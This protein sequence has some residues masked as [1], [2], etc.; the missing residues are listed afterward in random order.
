MSEDD[1]TVTRAAPRAPPVTVPRV[2]LRYHIVGYVGRGGMGTV[3]RVIDRELGEIVALKVLG[4]D[5]RDTPEALGMFR[6]EARL[7]R[8][9]T[10][11]NV[12]RIYDIGEHEGDRFLTMELVE[13]ESLRT[14]SDRHAPLP[15]PEVVRIGTALCAGLSAIHAASI[16]HLDLKPANVLLDPHGRIAITDFGVARALSDPRPGAVG[17]P[18]YMAPEQLDE[19]GKVDERTDLYAVGA[20]LYE[21]ATGN[22][23]WDGPP[24]L[25]VRRKREGK[26]PNPRD[27][28]ASLPDAFVDVVRRCLACEP[29]E[30]PASADEVAGVLAEITAGPGF[31]PQVPSVRSFGAQKH[32]V[33]VSFENQAGPGSDYL[34]RGVASELAKQL[35]SMSGLRIRCVE[36]PR[37]KETDFYRTLGAD[38]VVDGALLPD[39][40]MELRAVVVDDGYR[41]WSR[42]FVDAAKH[43]AEIVSGAT[44]ALHTALAPASTRA[45]SA[46]ADG[47]AHDLYLRGRY[48]A[49]R[50]WFEGGDESARLLGEAHAAA[51]HDRQ[52]AAAYALALARQFAIADLGVESCEKARR[53]ARRVLVDGASGTAHVALALTHWYCGEGAAAASELRLAAESPPPLSASV[54]EWLGTVLLEIGEL[55]RGLRLVERASEIEPRFVHV[56]RLRARRAALLGDFATAEREL[57]AEPD[58]RDAEANFGFRARF[59]LWREDRAAAR[60]MMVERNATADG[61]QMLEICAERIISDEARRAID[62]LLP[63]AGNPRRTAWYAQLRAE[64]FAVAGGHD[65]VLAS[66]E[67]LE[68]AYF[69][70]ILW[71]E[72]CPLI[73]RYSGTPRWNKLRE[74]VERRVR[75][76]REL[77]A[78]VTLDDA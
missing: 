29:S 30:R 60:A 47:T 7:A 18:M 1:E 68:D 75:P 28:V 78:D 23:A 38:V 59:L 11:P 24:D 54:F 42:T 66:L 32:V 37:A 14:Y 36:R 33:V 73:A 13:G 69:L 4:T 67:A 58:D 77:L 72:R 52:I 65:E 17:T 2:P 61:K 12:V 64:I 63:L 62:A 44:D 5:L 20:I 57:I 10:H 50:Q 35:R 15:L 41:L 49:P 16:V 19:K 34:A 25:L 26:V 56:A 6:D 45:V 76:I 22:R 53:I 8:R 21:L 51:P 3:Y 40:A 55:D 39:G 31:G 70:D 46:K 48:I 27:V 74:K 71:L 43:S 9:V